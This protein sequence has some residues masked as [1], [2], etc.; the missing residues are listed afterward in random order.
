MLDRPPSPA[1]VRARRARWRR[2]HG[3][4]PRRI[5][6]DEHALAEALILSSRLSADEALRP[7]PPAPA[8]MAVPLPGG[9][10]RGPWASGHPPRDLSSPRRFRTIQACPGDVPARRW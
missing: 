2:R 1:A 6:V 7:P 3:L 5:D 4:V 9:A 8:R 10:A